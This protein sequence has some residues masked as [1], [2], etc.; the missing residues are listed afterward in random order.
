MEETN[1]TTEIQCVKPYRI[2][3]MQILSPMKKKSVLDRPLE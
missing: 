1:W 3:D 2:D